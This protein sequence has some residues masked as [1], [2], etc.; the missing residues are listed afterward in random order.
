MIKLTKILFKNQKFKFI[1]S[2][3]SILEGGKGGDGAI[4]FLREKRIARGVIFFF[5]RL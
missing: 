1:D 5:K 3:R 2:K 4:S